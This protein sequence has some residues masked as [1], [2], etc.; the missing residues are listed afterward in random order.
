M[1]VAPI[2]LSRSGRNLHSRVNLVVLKMF[3]ALPST[4][5]CA[6]GINWSSA[7]LCRS[8]CG[9]WQHCS[10]FFHNVLSE[11][12]PFVTYA[13]VRVLFDLYAYVSRT[14]FITTEQLLPRL[15]THFVRIRMPWHRSEAVEALCS[16]NLN[17]LQHTSGAKGL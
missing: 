17:L 5:S 8:H 4:D 14:S 6:W 9:S 12:M 7:I 2:N 11:L 15:Y 16:G 13:F 3:I 1:I 10:W